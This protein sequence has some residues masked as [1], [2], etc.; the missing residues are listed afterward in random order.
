MYNFLEK[1][2]LFI[3]SKT[4]E[5]GRRRIIT[6]RNMIFKRRARLQ[7]PILQLY[8]SKRRSSRVMMNLLT[9]NNGNFTYCC[10]WQIPIIISISPVRETE[11]KWAIA[12]SSLHY[13][14]PSVSILVLNETSGRALEHIRGLCTVIIFPRQD[15]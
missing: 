4:M 1:V 14:F 11:Q 5:N 13:C 12:A 6:L 10:I 3:F 2:F 8:I 9:K 15:N 7:T